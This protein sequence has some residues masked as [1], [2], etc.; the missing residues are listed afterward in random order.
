[1]K[2]F[3]R[4]LS[5]I[6]LWVFVMNG[7]AQTYDFS[8]STGTY[9]NLTDPISINNG[10]TWDELYFEIPIG[11]D[12]K[13]F[14]TTITKL[15]ILEQALISVD[16]FDSG[17]VPFIAVSISDLVDRGFDFDKNVITPTSQSPISYNLTG[18][19]GNRILKLEWKNAGFYSEFKD[20]KI[21][22]D[23]TN[24]QL[25]LYEGSNDIEIHYGPTSVNHPDLSYDGYDGDMVSLYPKIRRDVVNGY[26]ALQNGIILTGDPSNPEVIN[27]KSLVEH[28]LNGT[29]PNGTIYKLSY[30][31][32]SSKSANA[33]GLNIYPNPVENVLSFD[34]KDG[35]GMDSEYSIVDLLGNQVKELSNSKKI[36]V[37]DLK[38]GVYF[39]KM[40]NAE[41]FSMHRFIKK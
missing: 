4:I 26:E 28:F 14:D 35:N 21:S 29:I 12:F 5:A 41:T 11:F 13:L 8:V 33:S 20:D 18:D 24:F 3:K 9:T 37:T 32:S 10:M 19:P 6:A 31:V 27:D 34:I 2:E 40:Q 16:T 23:Y 39:I 17:I 1:M 7:Q 22:E 30:R 36:D 25:W 15:G 38:S